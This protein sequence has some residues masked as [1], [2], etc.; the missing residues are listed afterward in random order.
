MVF[1]YAIIST[2]SIRSKTEETM[3]HYLLS[4]KLSLMEKVYSFCEEIKQLT[5]VK[6]GI[7]TKDNAIMSLPNNI[8]LSAVL[9]DMKNNKKLTTSLKIRVQ[10]LR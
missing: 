9:F 10:S 3:N 5:I 1:Y 8:K 6:F 7:H 4:V 2:I